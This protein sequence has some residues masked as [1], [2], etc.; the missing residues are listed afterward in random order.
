MATLDRRALLK[1]AAATG[2]VAGL[3][4]STLARSAVA[5]D[6]D[7]SDAEIY[8]VPTAD[9]LIEQR[10]DPFIT[11]RTGGM[12]YF[13]GSVPEYDRLVVRGAPTIAGL[14]AAAETVVWRR[15]ASGKM[16]GHI[17]AP[18][19]HRIDGR[20][21]IYFA[22]GDSDDVFRIRMY[23]LES[24]LPDP[25]DPAG[26][27]LRGQIAT[28]WDSFS[29]DATTFAHRG[30]RYLVWAQSEPEIAVNSSLYIARMDTP[31]SIATKPVRLTTPT[32]SWE[33]QGFRVNEGPA[34]IVRNGRVFLTFS[35][36]AT[37]ARYCMG[38]LTADAGADLLDRAC[39]AKTPDPVFVTDERTRR[40]GPGHNTF[41][42]AEDGVTDVLVYH[43]RD[44]RDI[45]GD[46]LYDPNRH[47]RVQK[48][49]WHRDGTPL[50]GVPVGEGGPIVR[51]SPVD[52]RDA[53]VRHEEGALRV[54][55]DVRE[56]AS[57]Q[58]RFVAAAAGDGTETIQSVDLP[59]RYVAVVGGT[60]RL[61]PVETA[62]HRVR[63]AGGVALRLAADP[64][65]YLL[66]DQGRL[67]V[68]SPG[69][70]RGRFLL[71]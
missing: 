6:P 12:Y 20:W 24:P 31:W 45:T 3:A 38:L 59:D 7:R 57:S 36:S 18:E 65:R 27:T 26:W 68:G 17:W 39:W 11:R 54:Q 1:G 2:I 62:F 50:F 40:Y 25:R 42:V 37:D 46:P 28:E 34:A 53:Y 71:S 9:P 61:D 14:A 51:L 5:G 32:R 10:A 29:L 48:L 63:G 70:A 47:T 21:Y 16:G 41:T 13:T 43:A 44:Y 33:I 22:A 8:G 66:H 30:R 55:R 64:E 56:L 60:V 15:P 49:Y 58:F 67:T 4:T 23:V 69:G 35:A 19:L 52:A